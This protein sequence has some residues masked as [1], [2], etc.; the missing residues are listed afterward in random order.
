MKNL[1][2]TLRQIYN[3]HP[4]NTS[5][6]MTTFGQYDN[7]KFSQI[8]DIFGNSELSTITPGECDW[9]FNTLLRDT[10]L[11][12]TNLPI[13]NIFAEYLSDTIKYITGQLDVKTSTYKAEYTRFMKE[14]EAF[15][16]PTTTKYISIYNSN[17]LDWR[18]SRK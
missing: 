14:R 18:L 13:W 17:I 11:L 3:S 2:I 10:N 12:H 16:N 15:R 8:I 5:G 9:A 1:S 4:E 7:R 6:T